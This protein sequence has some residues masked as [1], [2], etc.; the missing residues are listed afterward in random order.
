MIDTNV[1]IDDIL[2]RAPNA[3]VARKISQLV[4]DG[5]INGY[6]TAN[7]ITDIFYIVAKIKGNE[8]T[9]TIIRNLLG[10]FMIVSVDGQ[11]CLQ[12]LDLPLNDFEDAL[13]IICAQKTSLDYIITNDK[14]FLSETAISVPSISPDD[15]LL[16][17][18]TAD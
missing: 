10:T 7:S 4:E 14:G 1:I 16:K 9:R 15:F 11:D 6:I 2:N 13:V 8:I 17:F 5:I 3:V 18:T 12:A